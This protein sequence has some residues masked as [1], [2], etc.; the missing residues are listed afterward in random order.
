MWKQQNL[1]EN[2]INTRRSSVFNSWM[3]QT[4]FSATVFYVHGAN[5]MSS[6]RIFVLVLVTNVAVLRADNA[7]EFR[8]AGCCCDADVGLS[9]VFGPNF[10][11]GNTMTVINSG[12]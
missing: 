1:S 10:V 6:R 2:E 7:G 9:T 8:S 5:I 12:N 3:A 4:V 11:V